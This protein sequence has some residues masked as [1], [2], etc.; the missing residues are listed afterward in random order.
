MEL[1]GKG[2]SCGCGAEPPLK[3][4][5]VLFADAPAAPQP[6]ETNF[7]APASIVDHLET[8]AGRV[9]R[10]S[11]EV[12]TADVLGRWK[13]RWGIGRMGYGIPPGVYAFGNPGRNSPVVVTCNYKLTFDHLR[14]LWRGINLWVVAIETYAINVWC[15]AGKGTFGTAEVVRRVNAT[16]ISRLVDHRELILPQLGA[17]GVSAREVKK[18]TGFTVF[19]GPVR[20]A[21]LG[22]YLENGKT[23]TREMRRV[24][25]NALERLILTPIELTLIWKPLLAAFIVALV[26]SGFVP[27]GWQAQAAV[28]RGGILTGACLLG[29]VAGA[30]FTPVFLAWLP[31]R[32]FSL[33]GGVMAL[34]L[35]ALV[36]TQSGQ[37]LTFLEMA[38]FTALAVSVSSFAAMN[39]TGASTYTSPSGVTKEMRKSL[40]WQIAL[41]L[42]SI[43]GWI[44]GPYLKG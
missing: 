7:P 28:T 24:T 40:P 41:L 4:L 36:L 20:A 26:I 5:N 35:S 14:K 27:G 21:D 11:H 29:G 43:A 19:Y 22:A 31:F 30:F 25:F 12:T 3:K 18:E 10:V 1:N 17:P 6:P 16:G 13:S 34:L 37:S 2:S 23:A 32:M 15:A 42:F 44:A 8:E 38:A 33:K 39:F 9:P